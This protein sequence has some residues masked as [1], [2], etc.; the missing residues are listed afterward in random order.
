[1]AQTIEEWIEALQEHIK[2]AEEDVVGD[3]GRE[4]WE[5]GANDVIRSVVEMSGAPQEAIDEVL[6]REGVLPSSRLGTD[7]DWDDYLDSR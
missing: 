6:R 3:M 4:A 1:M 2:V 7:V 5:G